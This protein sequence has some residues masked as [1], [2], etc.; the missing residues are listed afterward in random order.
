M[1][2]GDLVNMTA[3]TIVSDDGDLRLSYRAP[4]GERF[5]FLLLGSEPK[6]GSKPLD[7]EAIMKHMG[8]VKDEAAWAAEAE[9]T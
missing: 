3:C 2:R 1:Q 9:K 8:W 6:D 4:K 5:V 7:G